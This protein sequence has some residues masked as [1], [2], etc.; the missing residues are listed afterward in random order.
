MGERKWTSTLQTRVY[1]APSPIH[2][3]GC[4]ARMTFTSGDFIGT[5]EGPKVEEDGTH[6]LWV[7]EAD[8]DRVIARRG[9]NLLRWV[10]HSDEPN[11]EFDGFDLYAKVA[12]VVDEEITCDYGAAL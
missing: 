1:A 6:V 4:F 10:N 5:Y 3:T 8:S 7:Y 12:I 11:A 2:G 9:T